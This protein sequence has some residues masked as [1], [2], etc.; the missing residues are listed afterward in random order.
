M[1]KYDCFILNTQKKCFKPKGVMKP[2]LFKHLC[3]IGLLLRLMY[4][5]L[6]KLRYIV[7]Y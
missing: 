2:N 3:K 4:Y 5:S 1:L 7:F 6:Y